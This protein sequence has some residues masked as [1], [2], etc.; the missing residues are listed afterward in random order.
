M[1][2][3]NRRQADAIIR[4]LEVDLKLRRQGT[5]VKAEAARLLVLYGKIVFYN[6]LDELRIDTGKALVAFSIAANQG[7]WEAHY[8]LSILYFYNLDESQEKNELMTGKVGKVWDVQQYLKTRSERLSFIHLYAA[9]LE[10]DQR[11]M[12]AMGNKY[13]K[14]GHF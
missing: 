1:L 3:A 2:E 8:Y 13:M 14:V 11:V 12:T 4:A 5:D 6:H 10:G 7:N 9:S